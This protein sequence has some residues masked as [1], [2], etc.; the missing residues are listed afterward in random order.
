MKTAISIFILFCITI[1]SNAQS[2][3]RP[4]YI[5][6]NEDDTIVGKID[7]RKDATMSVNCQFRSEKGEEISYAPGDIQAY[8]FIDGK[9]YVSRQIND[10]SLFLEYLINGKI[11]IYYYRDSDGDHYYIQK[12]S[13]ELTELEYRS[14]DQYLDGEL[15]S[16]HSNKH[17]GI[18]FYY[19]ADVPELKDEISRIDA[20]DHRSLIHLAE[21]YHNKVCEDESCIIYEKKTRGID[22]G[23]GVTTGFS[24]LADHDWYIDQN[25]FKWGAHLYFRL[26]RINEK[27]YL[28]TGVQFSYYK[29]KEPYLDYEIID[30][31]KVPV[32]IEYCFLSGRITPKVTGGI[33]FYHPKN[34]TV[35]VGAGA[36][37]RLFSTMFFTMDYEF[38][39]TTNSIVIPGGFFGHTATAGLM[40]MF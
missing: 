23:I 12:D 26:P 38:E 22:I 37:A 14:G 20:P 7:F 25:Y 4:G 15:Y 29:Y 24:N 17:N 35:S 39:M 21:D 40:Y 11:S 33:S 27:I 19:M 30:Y 9:Y 32:M 36:N 6:S 8:R 1:I 28:K 18:L 16:T 3:Y 13:G 2:D 10:K 31:T 34:Q 5:I